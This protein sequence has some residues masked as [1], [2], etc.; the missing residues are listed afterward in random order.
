[1][2]CYV[3]RK[4]IG[5]MA[6][7]KAK[8]YTMEEIQAAQKMLR[9]L[10]VKKS[11]KTRAETVEV[12]AADIRKAVRQGYSLKDVQE[13]LSKA[14]IAAPLARMKAL[15][16]EAEKEAAQNGEAASVA[17]VGAGA[18]FAASDGRGKGLAVPPDTDAEGEL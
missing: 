18:A 3:W 6:M 12:L 14:G 11:G 16:E 5:G 17:S 7:A 8:R 1:M 2:T 4:T 15:F 13:M 9:G 10:A